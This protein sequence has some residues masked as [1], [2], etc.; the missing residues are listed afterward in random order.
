MKHLVTEDFSQEQMFIVKLRINKVFY[1]DIIDEFQKKFHQNLYDCKI[2]TCLRRSAMGYRWAP[3][4]CGGSDPY[5]CKHDL[6][7]LKESI[8]DATNKGVPMDCQTVLDEA[9]SIKEYRLFEGAEFLSET[10][11]KKLCSELNQY[12]V[13]TPSRQWINSIL[14]ELD[15]HVINQ[16]LIDQ[17]RLDACSIVTIQ[18]FFSQFSVFISQFHKI[19]I[20]GADETMLNPNPRKKIVVPTEI[21]VH[22]HEDLPDMA[23][24]S[25][26]LCHNVAGVALPPFIILSKLKN[27]P[28]ELTDLTESQQIHVAST[29]SGFMTRDCFLLWTIHFIHFLT[30]YRAKIK[31]IHINKDA[32]LIL[33]GHTSRENPLLHY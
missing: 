29:D 8:L 11:S 18:N 15:I 9:K 21:Q 22:F 31:N 17:K 13:D 3:S 2:S 12:I 7:D 5:L 20:F 10:N 32:L 25:A 16:R 6:M 1:E 26:M 14:E 33:D 4:N 24:I 27:L 19:M 30:N 23:H 28:Q